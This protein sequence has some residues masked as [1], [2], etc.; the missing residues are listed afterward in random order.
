LNQDH[1]KFSHQFGSIRSGGLVAEVKKLHDVAFQLGLEEVKEMTR[2]KYLNI[3]TRRHQSLRLYGVFE[4][5]CKWG[6]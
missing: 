6:N 3:L 1:I 5:Y 2:G 4:G